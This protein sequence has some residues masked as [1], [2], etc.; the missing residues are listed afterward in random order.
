MFLFFNIEHNFHLI[1]FLQ[2]YQFQRQIRKPIFSSKLFTFSPNPTVPGPGRPCHCV[3]LLVMMPTPLVIQ[4]Y[5]VLHIVECTE[6]FRHPAPS[7]AVVLRVAPKHCVSIIQ[8][9]FRP[10]TKRHIQTKNVQW[11]NINF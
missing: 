11:K 4:Q 10:K 8:I 3:I 1:F 9:L 6:V 5:K 2:I 7:Q